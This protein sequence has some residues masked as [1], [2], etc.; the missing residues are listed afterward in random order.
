MLKYNDG[1]ILIEMLMSILVISFI[2]LLM[3]DLLTLTSTSVDKDVGFTK[4]LQI[5]SIIYQDLIDA[6][7]V[8]ADEDCLYFT[9]NDEQISYCINDTELIRKVDNQGY[10]RIASNLEIEIK[11][12]PIVYLRINDYFNIPVWGENE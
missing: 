5:S 10:E 2:M 1:I 4:E 9:E 7:K 3:L 8:E 12:K 6:S 11:T